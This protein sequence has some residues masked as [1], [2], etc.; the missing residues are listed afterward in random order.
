[1]PANKR[2][3]KAATTRTAAPAMATE[4]VELPPFRSGLS[5]APATGEP[6]ESCGIEGDVTDDMLA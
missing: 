2:I 3:P 4:L 5:V 1:M 6:G